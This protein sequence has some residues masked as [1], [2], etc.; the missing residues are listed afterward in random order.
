MQAAVGARD[1]GAVACELL[2]RTFLEIAGSG[3][4]SLPVPADAE[5]VL[6][7]EVEGGTVEEAQDR[8]REIARLFEQS[9]AT[10][11][12]LAL[13]APTESELWELRH[14]ASPM[15]ARLDRVLPLLTTG[16]RDVPERQ[17]TIRATV[18]W[19]I[20]LLSPE[21]KSLLT[22]LGVFSGDFS[23]DAAEAVVAG[24]PFVNAAGR[25]MRPSAVST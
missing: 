16:A 17:R 12:R 24:A 5:A 23:L 20:D 1:E 21:A 18:E 2:D 10:V 25:S 8:A 13:D 15:L 4:R 14:A 19:S 11:V 9:R 7:A 6:L 22:C 3:G